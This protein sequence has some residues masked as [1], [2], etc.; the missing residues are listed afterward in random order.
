MSKERATQLLLVEDNPGDV[1]LLREMFNEPG[2]HNI[3]LMFAE[4][5]SE[6]EKHLAERAVDVV[7][8]DLGLPDAKGLGALRRAHAAAPR[9]PLVVLTGLNDE[10][11][12]MRALRQGAQD[13]L[14]KGSVDAGSIA[15]SIRHA[16]ERKRI[17]DILRF[18]GQCRV[19]DSGEE[20]FRELAHYLAQTLG[21]D[22]VRIDLLEEDRLSARTLA[23]FHDGKFEE[24]F[25]IQ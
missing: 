23:V 9:V 12:A 22:F 16:I 25:S 21:M 24:S 8:L 19:G 6:A 18:L 15:R 5:M 7:V 4:S 3:E 2:S 17:E 14:V 11:L 20:F 1:R 10:A 13:Y